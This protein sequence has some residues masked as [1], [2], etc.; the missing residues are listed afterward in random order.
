MI[1]FGAFLGAVAVTNHFMWADFPNFLR[2]LSD[3]VAITGSGHW[4]ATTN[5]G[6]YYLDTLTGPGAGWALV[7]LAAGFSAH[8]LTTRDPRRWIVVSFPVLYIW[9]MTQRP[10]Q[11]PRWVYPMLPYVAVAGSAA[12]VAIARVLRER[13]ASRRQPFGR[14]A[15][16][17]V[18]GLIL[19]VLSQPAWGGAIS[20]SRRVTPTTHA[21]TE[22]WLRTNAPEGN[23]VLLGR[24]WLDVRDAPFSTR[25][26]PN[27]RATLDAGL[28]PL[29][30]CNWVVVPEPVFGHP[31]LKHLAL[32]ERF[33]ADYG[34]GGNLGYD[35]EV[36][37]V[38]DLPAEGSCGGSGS[39]EGR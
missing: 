12:L 34:F 3:Q 8:A 10:S 38:P 11:F 28:E 20:F 5:P 39:G 29:A 14:S 36:Y 4:G 17:A 22:S 32:T 7:V 30:G 21:L 33:I 19:A 18:A 13:I 25:R 26:V 15:E 27:L 31:A 1:A 6:R 35:Y 9:F 24:G 2:Q 37:A 23:I 16:L